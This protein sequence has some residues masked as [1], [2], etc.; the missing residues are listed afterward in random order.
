MQTLHMRININML[1]ILSSYPVTAIAII[2]RMEMVRGYSI[3]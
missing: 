1:E 2:G 3:G